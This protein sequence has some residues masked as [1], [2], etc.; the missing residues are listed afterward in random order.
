MLHNTRLQF[1]GLLKSKKLRVFGVFFILSLLILIVTKLSEIYIETISF[2]VEYKNLP[3]KNLIILDS[4]PKVDVT[5]STYGFNL[6]SYYFKDK[7]YELDLQK[8][9]HTTTATH[10]NNYVW[11]AHTGMYDFKQLLGKNVDIISVKPDTLILPFGTLSSKRVPIV[12]NSKINFAPG[13]NSLYGISI[14]PDSIDIMG[15]KKDI[16][17]I[18]EVETKPLIL[19]NI[20]LDI[21]VNIDIQNKDNLKKIKMS[22]ERVE[23]FAKVEK[24]T[25]GV[26]D[27]PITILNVPKAIELNYFPKQIKVSYYLSLSNYKEV[28]SSDFSIECDYD[29]AVKS[30]NFYFTPKLIV[31]SSK[32]KSARLKQNKVEY[33]I[34]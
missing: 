21:D 31:N 4:I 19:D 1:G 25:E 12:L 32:V 33:I 28:I 27:I 11:L 34:K 30:E 20:K 2:S 13:Y 7:K 10:S 9:A 5:M 23:V 3:D 29:E 18:Y 26:F 8:S 22:N 16:D 14:T 15:A 6:L 17:K 24:F